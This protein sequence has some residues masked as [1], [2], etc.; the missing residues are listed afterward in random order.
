MMT[1]GW[2]MC[3][4]GG[5][6]RSLAALMTVVAFCASAQAVGPQ[7]VLIVTGENSL[8]A[9]TI[10]NYYREQRGIP[11]I[12]VVRLP[13]GLTKSAHVDYNVFRTYV[14]E[15]VLKHIERYS[16]QDR[17]SVWVTTPSMPH[18]V[19]GEMGLSGAIHFGKF[20]SPVKDLRMPGTF[21][22]KN[23]YFDAMRAF[24][25]PKKGETGY[26]HMRLDAGSLDATRT[27]I[28]R[29]IKADGSFPNGTVYFNDGDGPRSSRKEMIAPAMQ[30]LDMLGIKSVRRPGSSLTGAKD[31]IGWQTGVAQLNPA[32]NRYLPGALADHLTSFGGQLTMLR[33]QTPA[34]EFIKAGCSGTY[35]TVAEPYNYPAKF[36]VAQ[37]FVFYGIGFTAVESYWM[38]VMWPQQ[39]VFIG[40]PLT[41]PFD[42]APTIDVKGVS[43]GDEAKGTL[44]IDVAAESSQSDGGVQRIE[45]YIDQK[46]VHQ[47]GFTE[48]P[49]ETKVALKVG[50]R[51]IE[52]SA[53]EESRFG[54]FVTRFGQKIGQSGIKVA[55][56]PGL[57]ILLLPN[58]PKEGELSVRSSSELFSAQIIGDKLASSKKSDV[59]LSPSI[60]PQ[61]KE[62]VSVK[63]ETKDSVSGDQTPVPALEKMEWQLVGTSGTGDKLILTIREKGK[64]VAHFEHVVSFPRPAS[65]VC[66]SVW[67]DASG[68]LPAGYRLRNIPTP[69]KPNQGKLEL[70]ADT[71]RAKAQPTATLELK[72]S[73]DSALNIVGQTADAPEPKEEKMPAASPPGSLE[74]AGHLAAIRFGVG[75][76]KLTTRPVIDTTT[77]PDG[78]HT[79]EIIAIRGSV[80]EASS[81]MAMPIVIR[82]TDKKF[83]LEPLTTE[84]SFKKPERVEVARATLPPGVGGFIRYF[85][86]DVEAPPQDLKDGNLL[87]TPN[88]WGPGKHSVTAR[89]FQGP[90]E[91]QYSDNEVVFTVTP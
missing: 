71:S 13:E 11:A 40:D 86:D 50:D 79:L 9:L 39:G 20:L 6:I 52:Y 38:S 47:R 2:M 18:I 82:N 89:V 81:R 55:I 34:I 27:L 62:P 25:P 5:I 88:V 65:S 17:I 69:E 75:P 28:D 77:F 14:Y 51:T 30:W 32:L 22:D 29:S 35:G 80:T 37:L 46:L 84:L 41:R 60:I 15:A 76:A 23:K 90:T 73:G 91:V 63:P 58:K 74:L 70:T 68:K 44:E 59:K 53:D 31:V 4:Q 45:V 87:V 26:L 54:D 42:A 3:R 56:K 64:E 24:G 43:P 49:A 72:R 48:I 10:A 1:V 19:Q 36:P 78:R 7:N 66:T 83:I 33:G 85:I 21:E 16:L 12:N 8:E 67:L 57:L 61:T